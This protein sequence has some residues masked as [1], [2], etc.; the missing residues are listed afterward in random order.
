MSKLDDARSGA[1]T[2]GGYWAR[3][4]P[5]KLPKKHWKKWRSEK[6]ELFCYFF[7]WSPPPIQNPTYATECPRGHVKEN[8]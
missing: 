5:L 3:A 8:Y 2:G 4:P 1:G 7:Q 6:N